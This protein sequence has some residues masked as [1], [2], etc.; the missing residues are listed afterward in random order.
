MIQK[1]Q[2]VLC[3]RI[4]VEEK[5]K[6]IKNRKYYVPGSGQLCKNC[7]ESTYNKTKN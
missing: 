7:Y 3:G 6:P 5:D 1:D 4:T 2:C